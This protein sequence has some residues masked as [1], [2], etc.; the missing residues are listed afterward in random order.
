MVFTATARWNFR[1]ET[2]FSVEVEAIDLDTA[3]AL[4]YS[5]LPATFFRGSNRLVA[6]RPQS[7][8]SFETT[9]LRQ[10]IPCVKTINNADETSE[11]SGG[12]SLAV[13]Q[14]PSG[15]AAQ[16]YRNITSLPEHS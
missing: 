9:L 7:S 8:G 6:I 2:W 11:R 12:V 14:P 10:P 5:M 4:F 15:S 1:G 3:G 16:R 13:I